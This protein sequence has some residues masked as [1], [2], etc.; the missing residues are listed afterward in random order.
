MGHLRSGRM[1]ALL[2][3]SEK[4][5]P[6]FPDVSTLSELGYRGPV[7]R[8]YFGLYAPAGM[9]QAM[10]EKVAADVGAATSDPAFREKNLFQRGL[11]PV[12]STP[13]EFSEFLKQDRARAR[14]VIEQGGLTA[15]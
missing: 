2:I 10:R 8:S 7:T 11:E 13:A 1:T 5:L 6:I 9:P 4:R 14:L 15:Q 12:F 3:D